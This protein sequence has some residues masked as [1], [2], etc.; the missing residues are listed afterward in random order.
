MRE[1]KGNGNTVDYGYFLDGSVRSM[2]EKTSAGVRVAEHQFDYDL[3]GNRTKDAAS[4][5]NADNHGALVATA[6][7]G[8]VR[9]I[10]PGRHRCRDR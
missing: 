8:H 4:T 6:S 7:T 1:V 10:G 2:L 9:P 5:M 3:N